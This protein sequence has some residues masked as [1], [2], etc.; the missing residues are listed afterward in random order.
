MGRILNNAKLL[1]FRDQRDHLQLSAGFVQLREG[2][3]HWRSIQIQREKECLLQLQNQEEACAE[4][5]D[6]N[7]FLVLKI[8]KRNWI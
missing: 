7:L 2:D 5:P 6:Q 4:V 1:Y 3:Q 8:R